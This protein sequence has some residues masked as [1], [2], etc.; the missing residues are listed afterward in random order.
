[1][2]V[3]CGDVLL[4]KRETERTTLTRNS[5]TQAFKVQKQEVTN[6]NKAVLP[7][8]AEGPPAMV[9]PVCRQP[10]Y[11]QSSQ[12]RHDCP[13]FRQ[14]R[15]LTGLYCSPFRYRRAPSFCFVAPARQIFCEVLCGCRLPL[16][17]W[18]GV[19][20]TRPGFSSVAV[21]VACFF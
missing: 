6:N 4:T 15:H 1:M 20:T 12:I 11:S 16:F 9:C 14:P 2:S 3:A 21:W 5:T 10:L 18:V 13:V 19:R 7:G 8:R 17:C